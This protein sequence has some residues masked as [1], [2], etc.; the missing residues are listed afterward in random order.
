MATKTHRAA[1]R[2]VRHHGGAPLQRENVH[3]PCLPGGTAHA[4]GW[5]RR[6]GVPELNRRPRWQRPSIWLAWLEITTGLSVGL[7]GCFASLATDASLALIGA[8]Y[9]FLVGVI[10]IAIPGAILLG[11]SPRRWLGQLLPLAVV[12]WLLLR[13]LRTL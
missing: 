7:G 9:A 2:E 3:E 6:A 10:V 13:W 5:M 12:L 1:I 8:V 11:R 4:L